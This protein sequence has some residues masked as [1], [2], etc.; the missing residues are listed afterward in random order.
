MAENGPTIMEVRIEAC[1]TA[2]NQTGLKWARL[3]KVDENAPTNAL[4][5][6][7]ML[8]CDEAIDVFAW[9]DMDGDS[10]HLNT[11]A[12]SEVDSAS[13]PRMAMCANKLNRRMRWVKFC[14]DDAGHFMAE[15]DVSLIGEMVGT[16][17]VEAIQRMVAIIDECYSEIMVWSWM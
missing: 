5:M 4:V 17:C 1:E 2:L 13:I 7:F 16:L 12:I 3:S 15:C 14:V 10:V 11:G 9:F 8:G 6:R